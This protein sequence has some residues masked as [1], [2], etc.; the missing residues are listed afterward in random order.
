MINQK[1]IKK[2]KKTF[3]NK[4]YVVLKNFIPRKLINEIKSDVTKLLEMKMINNKLENI[5]YLKTKQ[6]SSVHNIANYMSYH[7]KFLNGTRIQKIFHGIFGPS[8]KKWFNSS[9]FLKPKKVGISTKAHQDNAFFNLNPCEAFT[10]W[11]PTD[12]VTKQNSSLYYYSGSNKGGLL[13]HKPQGNPGASLCIPQKYINRVRK[14]YKKHYVQV[15]KGDCI[16]H[17]PLVIHGSER[18]RSSIDRGAFNFS[19]KSKKAKRDIIGWNNY[20]KKLS[21]YLKIRKRKR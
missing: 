3:H 10:C 9:Y 13:P 7:K 21:T 16:I 15:K 12:S 4:G 20:R 11:V 18:N 5:H 19:I 8:E 1:E 6:L 17:N 2:I 14:K